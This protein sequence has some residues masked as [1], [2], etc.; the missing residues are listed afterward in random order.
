MKP[1]Y[2]SVPPI[3]GNVPVLLL[4]QQAGAYDGLMHGKNICAIVINAAIPW[5]IKNDVLIDA[6][7]RG[8]FLWLAIN[9]QVRCC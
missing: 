1:T 6:G 4:G 9:K 8:L 3:D 2:P 5:A 7:T